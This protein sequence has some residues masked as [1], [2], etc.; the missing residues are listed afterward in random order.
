MASYDWFRMMWTSKNV[1]WKFN[2]GTCVPKL[3]FTYS[4]YNK[5]LSQIR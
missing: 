5:I 3:T 1:M 4:T 2:F